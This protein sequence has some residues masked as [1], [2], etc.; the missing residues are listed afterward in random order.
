MAG[1]NLIIKAE[2]VKDV[3]AHMD[4]WLS[5]SNDQVKNVGSLDYNEVMVT[6]E[7]DA[8]YIP[9]QLAEWHTETRPTDGGPFEPGS[10]IWWKS[11]SDGSGPRP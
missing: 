1:Y 3:T 7:S 6:L 9:R 2:R 5:Y 11:D 4:N 8:D 10:L